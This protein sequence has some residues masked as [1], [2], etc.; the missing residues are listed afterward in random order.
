MENLTGSN[1][2]LIQLNYEMSTSQKSDL[3]QQSSSQHATRTSNRSS[4]PQKAESGIKAKRGRR[5][6]TWSWIFRNFSGAPVAVPRANRGNPPISR[7]WSFLTELGHSRSRRFRSEHSPVINSLP[8]FLAVT[9]SRSLS[10]DFLWFS[11]VS[12]PPPLSFS[13]TPSFA[14]TASGADGEKHGGK[15][16]ET[17]S[18]RKDRGSGRGQAQGQGS[19]ELHGGREEASFSSL[20]SSLLLCVQMLRDCNFAQIPQNSL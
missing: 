7:R 14:D 18:S 1:I 8:F 11:I 10:V 9:R 16:P 17:V 13:L 12:P 6:R 4:K 2:Y 20:I 15:A 19:A 3:L 5:I